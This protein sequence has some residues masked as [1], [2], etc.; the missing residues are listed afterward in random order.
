L[1]KPFRYRVVCELPKNAAP[2]TPV[3]FIGKD[4]TVSLAID[5][6]TT[7]RVFNG[8]CAAV[9]Q[10][11]KRA[12]AKSSDGAFKIS[13]EYHLVVEPFF[14]LLRHTKNCR[15]FQQKKLSEIIKAVSGGHKYANFKT[16]LQTDPQIQYC[17]QY[18]ESDYNFLSRLTRKH[19]VY[20]LFKHSGDLQSGE[21]EIY[22]VDALSDEKKNG[23]KPPQLG[24]ENLL[25]WES[26][27]RLV[28]GETAAIAYTIAYNYNTPRADLTACTAASDP[29]VPAICKS[30]RRFEYRYGGYAN[31]DAGNE[32]TKIE[33][34]REQTRCC[35][36]SAEISDHR[37]RT[38]YA[39]E[40]DDAD[41]V[42]DVSGKK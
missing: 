11:V 27:V 25:N 41:S 9:K 16:I 20:Y 18:N 33:L 13:V 35:T 1:A 37:L 19:G 31:A 39:F 30:M 14:A 7:P 42:L 40:V 23:G 32:W 24:A 17:V 15:I 5:G 21:H 26:T 8:V 22:F 10:K 28:P 38:G 6:Q 2:Q 12:R 36:F 4:V 3:E 29:L 34:E